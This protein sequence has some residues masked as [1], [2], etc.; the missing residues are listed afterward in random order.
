MKKLITLLFVG[1]FLSS[2][3]QKFQL[4]DSE[5]NP[6]TNGQT[7]YATITVHDWH[8]IGDYR[9]NITMENL[10]ASALEMD[11]RCTAIELIEGAA[12]EVCLDGCLSGEIIE[13][14]T[15]IPEGGAKIYPLHILFPDNTFGLN[16]FKLEF[17]A[18]GE[19]ITLHAI[20]DMCG[21]GVKEQ[22][23]A[24]VSL[25]AFPNPAP[26]N[27]KINVSYTLAD[28][29]DKHRL[30]VRNILGAA[31]MDM[32]LNSYENNISIDA[33]TLKSGVYLYTIETKNQISITRKLI[34][35]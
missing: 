2:F 25:S 12:V 16:R 10:T 1:L 30:V 7:I 17:M 31:V 23:N 24:N 18:G 29:N 13:I 8:P 20:I 5:G 15:E 4:T 32:P 28:K 3:A 33:S 34:V 19:T 22:N 26:A 35:K 27:S 11:T 21:V 9:L 6:Y 14:S